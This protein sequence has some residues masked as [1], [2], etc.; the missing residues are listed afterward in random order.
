MKNKGEKALKTKKK[1]KFLDK[2]NAEG[3]LSLLIAVCSFHN[4]PGTLNV[5][6]NSIPKCQD[7]ASLV[8][9]SA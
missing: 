1:K 6:T 3:L 2:W 9:L 8:T 7:C 4:H 5:N